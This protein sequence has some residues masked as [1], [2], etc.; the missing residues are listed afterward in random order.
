[1]NS[2]L[3]GEPL[4]KVFH[5]WSDASLVSMSTGGCW[6]GGLGIDFGVVYIV[7]RALLSINGGVNAPVRKRPFMVDLEG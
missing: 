2:G 5:Y 6:N 3:S 4:Q 1:M 7:S